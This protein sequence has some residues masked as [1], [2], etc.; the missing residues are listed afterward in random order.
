[1]FSTI[2]LFDVF[3]CTTVLQYTT[4]FIWWYDITWYW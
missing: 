4:I 3:D 2:Y 1:M